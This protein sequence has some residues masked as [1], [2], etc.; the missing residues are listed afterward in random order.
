MLEEGAAGSWQYEG[1]DAC[2]RESAPM[3]AW[4]G[5]PPRNEQMQT[6]LHPL[7]MPLLLLQMVEEGSTRLEVQLRVNLTTQWNL[8]MMT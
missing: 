4:A 3:R 1:G 5:L 7:L 6:L 8:R 2:R